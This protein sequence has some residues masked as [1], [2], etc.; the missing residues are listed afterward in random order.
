MPTTAAQ[1][2]VTTGNVI[3]TMLQVKLGA[4]TNHPGKVV[5]WGI[6]FDGSA[7]A[8]PI[9]C[10]LLTTGT[11]NATVTEYVAALLLAGQ[12]VNFSHTASGVF[13]LTPTAGHL[14]FAG[15]AVDLSR[16]FVVTPSGGALVWNGQGVQLFHQRYLEANAAA[17]A[18]TGGSVSMMHTGTA[19]VTIPPLKITLDAGERYID[20]DSSQRFI[21]LTADETFIKLEE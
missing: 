6:S 16:S 18:L 15:Q 20:L 3:K 2:A 14:L 13:T 1:A 17:L 12:S 21:D 8:T 4:S 7:A 9:K 11:V 5:E 10:E 19:V